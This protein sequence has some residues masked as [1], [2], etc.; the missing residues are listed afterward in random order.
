[1]AKVSLKSEI[2]SILKNAKAENDGNKYRATVG[3][4]TCTFVTDRLN[5]RDEVIKAIAKKATSMFRKPSE[6][7][8]GG[9]MRQKQM[10][11]LVQH[12]HLLQDI[13]DIRYQYLVNNHT[14]EKA[15]R[16]VYDYKSCLPVEV[17]KRTRHL[18]R[19]EFVNVYSIPGIDMD[20]VMELLPLLPP[21]YLKEIEF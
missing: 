11:W 21:K 12:D 2:E 20:L 10:L 1:M 17:T 6:R 14:I 18:G 5:S 8:N 16:L 4:F 3:N 19:G 15:M 7:I 9:L 13:A